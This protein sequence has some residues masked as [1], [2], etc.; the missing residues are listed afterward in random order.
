M[1]NYIPFSLGFIFTLVPVLSTHNEP[2]IITAIP[3]L[4][5][6]IATKLCCPRLDCAVLIILHFK[7]LKVGVIYLQKALKFV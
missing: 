3:P 5:V 4:S 6:I 2:I 1:L 7:R